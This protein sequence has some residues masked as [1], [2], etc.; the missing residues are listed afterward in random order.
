M[1]FIKQTLLTK[2]FR[3]K[4]NLRSPTT[5]KYTQRQF[6]RHTTGTSSPFLVHKIISP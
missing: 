5:A 4:P 6:F 1:R 3:F 2:C